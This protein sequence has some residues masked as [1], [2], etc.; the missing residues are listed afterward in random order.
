[1]IWYKEFPH[2]LPLNSLV[3][4]CLGGSVVEHLP[5]AQGMV[6]GTW[7]LVLHWALDRE[8]AYASLPLSVSHE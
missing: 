3:V 5:S 1:M 6:P 2:L 8:P 7:D 4:G